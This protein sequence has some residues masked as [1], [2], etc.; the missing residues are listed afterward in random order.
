MALLDPPVETSSKTRHLKFVAVALVV[1]AAV[2]LYLTFRF[3]PEQRAAQRFFVAL[4]AGDTNAA[5]QLWKAGPS[6]HLQDFLADWG[7]HGYYGPVKSYKILKIST[8][9]DSSNSVAIEVE[10]SPFSPMPDASDAEKSRKTRVVTVWM[11]TQDK[12]F[13]FPPF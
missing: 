5:Y 12:S 7:P 11:N 10:V 8:P 1:L 13:S 6:Y 2:V 3:Y 4:V 9:K